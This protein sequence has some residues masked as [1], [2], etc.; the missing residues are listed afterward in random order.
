MNT[1]KVGKKPVT[2]EHPPLTRAEFLALLRRAAQPL[3]KVAG[4][5]VPSSG[6]TSESHRP[7]G[8]TETHTHQGKTGGAEG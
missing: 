1:K 2:Q 3:K 7:D 6:Q 8:C 4:E 5:L